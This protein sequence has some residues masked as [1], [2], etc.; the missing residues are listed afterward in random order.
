MKHDSFTNAFCFTIYG[1]DIDKYYAPVVEFVENRLLVDE[2]C[3]IACCACDLV[4]V[5]KVFG[6]YNN[7]RLVPFPDA[8]LSRARL[9]RFLLP[10]YVEADFFHFRDS[11]SVVSTR[12]RTFLTAWQHLEPPVLAIRD[13]PLHFSPILAGMISMKRYYAKAFAAELESDVGTVPFNSPYYDQTYLVRKIYTNDIG[14]IVVFTSYIRFIG[15]RS[16]LVRPDPLNFVGM[17][18]W[19]GSSEIHGSYV[20]TKFLSLDMRFKFIKALSKL[21]QRKRFV[22]A[23]A[24]L[25]RFKLI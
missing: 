1:R 24:I 7:V 9:L 19:W 6:S 4:F 10:L 2:V 16:V 23:L 3:A 8:L 22:Y 21:Y 20:G 17:P 13:H 25:H 18:A 5:E 11:D 15:E 12:E 14:K